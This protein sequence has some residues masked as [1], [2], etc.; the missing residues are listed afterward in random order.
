MCP[1]TLEVGHRHHDHLA[2]AGPQ[3]GDRTRQVGHRGVGGHQVGEVVA[4][5]VHQG[6]VR[7]PG[8]RPGDLGG[9]VGAAGS[10]DREDPGLRH[11]AVGGE[12]GHQARGE[13]LAHPGG[14]GA[15]GDGVSQQGQAQR[16]HGPSDAAGRRGVPG[17]SAGTGRGRGPGRSGTR[18][19]PAP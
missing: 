6:H 4:A 9:Q 7:A 13:G 19:W 14:A 12:V 17:S 15:G 8:Q 1:T 18:R 5:D 2:P 3:R 16:A 11:H 10:R